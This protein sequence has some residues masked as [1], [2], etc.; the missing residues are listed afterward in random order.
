MPPADTSIV[1]HTSRL[2]MNIL[3][4]FYE[5]INIFIVFGQSKHPIS[6]IKCAFYVYKI[7]G[8]YKNTNYT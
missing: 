8:R 7:F 1:V 4:N 6:T 2:S 5:K 3:I